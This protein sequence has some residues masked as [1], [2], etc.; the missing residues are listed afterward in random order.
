MNTIH[1]FKWIYEKFPWWKYDNTTVEW[2][3]K[4]VACSSGHGAVWCSPCMYMTFSATENEMRWQSLVLT[5]LKAA[6]LTIL[7][8]TVAS[9]RPI[10]RLAAVHTPRNR[11]FLRARSKQAGVRRAAM[12]GR[13]M[14]V[15]LF[16]PFWNCIVIVLLPRPGQYICDQPH[17]V[18]TW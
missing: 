8:C 3:R 11:N 17:L 12:R 6:V 18:P 4:L 7:P 2:G 14:I 9:R 10:L 5:S 1:Y 13:Q 16:L 15:G